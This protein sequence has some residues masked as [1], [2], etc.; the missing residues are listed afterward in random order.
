MAANLEEMTYN[1]ATG[2]SNGDE[3]IDY[4]NNFLNKI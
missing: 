1:F 2:K 4:V 3:I